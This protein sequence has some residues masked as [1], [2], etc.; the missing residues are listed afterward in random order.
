[1]VGIQLLHL[2]HFGQHNVDTYLEGSV[3]TI[4]G[5]GRIAKDT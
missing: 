5:G 4:S 2:Q 3:F 1:M